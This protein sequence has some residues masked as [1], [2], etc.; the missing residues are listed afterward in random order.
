[1][2]TSRAL[3][4]AAVLLAHTSALGIAQEL[5]PRSGGDQY[6]SLSDGYWEARSDLRKAGLNLDLW[7]TQFYQGVVS[8]AGSRQWQ[9]GGKGD[10][11]ATFDA[12]KFGLWQG[13]YINVH[14][15][16]LTGKDANTQG[17]GSL[18]PLN[19]A[20][21]FP[22]LGGHEQDVS[23]I[24]TQN[25]NE[26]VSLSFGKFNMLDAAAKTPLIGG[27]GI[28]TFMNT[29]LAAPISGVTPPYLLGGLLTVKTDPVILGL[30]VYDPRNAQD[31]EVIE[32]PFAKGAT[33]SLSLTFPVQIAGLTGY[34]GVRGV[35][36]TKEGTNL[37]DVPALLLPPA[38]QKFI[39]TKQGF[40]FV[41]ASFQQYLVQSA[42]NPAEGWG[43]FGQIAMSDGNPNPIGKSLFF[44]LGG[45]GF[46][47][48]RS[49]DL[50]G[51]GYFNTYLSDVLVDGLS[52]LGFNFRNEEGIE[53]YYNIAITPWFRLT[54]DVQV[55]QPH[56]GTLPVAVVAA[57]RSQIKF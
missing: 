20:L 37:A 14:A 30:L 9:S 47:P 36:S 29:A 13:L 45:T 56:I 50:W 51:I 44:G 21:A 54:A 41:S 46:I 2:A 48:G 6:K 8:G 19:T 31:R 55:I 33:T 3:V 1:M 24:V 53:A 32:H 28:N 17:D 42:T 27:G 43:L 7:Y 10:V 22:R 52:G 5:S 12:S 57:L 40:W 18:I 25:F 49:L 39:G 38:A 26:R 16:L 4:L 23:L 35:Y 34:Y 11:I 15:E